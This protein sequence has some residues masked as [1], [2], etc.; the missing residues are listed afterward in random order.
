MNHCKHPDLVYKVERDDDDEGT[1]V[2]AYSKTRTLGNS[3]LY[4]VAHLHVPDNNVRHNRWS[5]GDVHVDEDHRRRGIATQ[6]YQVMAHEL[7]S[8][9]SPSGI[10]SPDGKALWKSGN[11]LARCED[12]HSHS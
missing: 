7:G 11:L 5:A 1:F 10:L 9:P 4:A 12:A 3:A 2:F 8:A 6:M